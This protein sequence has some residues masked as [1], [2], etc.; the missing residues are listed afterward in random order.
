[1]FKVC[2]YISPIGLEVVTSLLRSVRET[3]LAGHARVAGGDRDG[4]RKHRSTGRAPQAHGGHVVCRTSNS[5]PRCHKVNCIGRERFLV[6]NCPHDFRRCPVQAGHKLRHDLHI[7]HNEA[8]ASWCNRSAAFT[9]RSRPMCSSQYSGDRPATPTQFRR[10][11]LQLQ[12]TQPSST[13]AAP[14]SS[15]TV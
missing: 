12:H 2:I 3:I 10:L 4:T 1:M 9:A 11:G 13:A 5:A 8:I 6:I 7:G 15:P 14:P